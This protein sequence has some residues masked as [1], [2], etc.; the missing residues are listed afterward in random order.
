MQSN[1]EVKY[2]DTHVPK[3]TI[4]VNRVTIKLNRET[5]V[6]D[7]RRIVDFV[8]KIT[9]QV[10]KVENT[11]RGRF[12]LHEAS[13]EYYINLSVETGSKK[14]RQRINKYVFLESEL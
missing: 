2:T 3:L 11:L 7:Q 4:A 1:W 13:G 14:N 5:P 8:D 9:K 12:G 6:K 10:G